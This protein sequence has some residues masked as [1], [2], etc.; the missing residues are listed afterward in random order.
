MLQLTP[1]RLDDQLA[2]ENTVQPDVWAE[3]NELRNMV[4]KLKMLLQSSGNQTEGM[5]QLNAVPVAAPYFKCGLTLS[6]FLFADTPKVAFSFASGLHGYFGPVKSETILIFPRQITNVGNAYNIITGVFTAPVKG[7]YYFRFNLLGKSDKYWTRVRL[8]KN[9]ESVIVSFTPPNPDNQYT[10]GGVT[11]EL[12]E[13][14]LRRLDD[15]LAVKNI[16]SDVWTE[17]KELRNMVVKLKMLLPSSGNQTEGMM[18]LH[19]DTPKV[20]F[21]FASGVHGYYGP[22][23]TETTLVFHKQITNVGNAYNVITG[24]FTAPV[25]GV[26]YFRFNL[27]GKSDKYRTSVHLFKNHE[28]VIKSSTPPNLSHE[29]TEFKNVTGELENEDEVLEDENKGL[30][31]EELVDEEDWELERVDWKLED[32]NEELMDEED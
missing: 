16:H 30:E 12:K 8:F 10:V 21:S 19:A 24:V 29:Y 26:Y 6:M 22:V 27:L 11:L 1:R 15:Q 18:Q 17:L 5:M 13:D 2:V 14:Q 7:V 32:D 23:T 20:A 3:L 9:H 4:V 25:R 28:R 31:D